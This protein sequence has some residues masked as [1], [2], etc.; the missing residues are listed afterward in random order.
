MTKTRI[1]MQFK[2]ETGSTRII[3]IDRPR[4]DITDTDVKNA[5]EEILA[6]KALSTKNGLLVEKVKAFKETVEQTDYKIA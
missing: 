3:S 4:E 6:A 1:K 2:D 5:M